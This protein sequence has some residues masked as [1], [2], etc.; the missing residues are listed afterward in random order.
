MSAKMKTLEEQ[1]QDYQR[2][3]AV[4]KE[5]LCAKEEHYNMLQADVEELRQRLEEKNR[6]IEKKTQV[7]MQATQE[8]NRINNELSE[9]KDHMDIK[10]RKINV[11][12]RKLE[13]HEANQK[14]ATG[15]AKAGEESSI[16]KKQVEEQKR[17]L[18]EQRR[19][20]E[21]HRKGLDTRVKQV[22]EKEKSIAEYEM[23]LK[24]RKENLD[25]REAQLQ[26]GGGQAGG[27]AE[28]VQKLEIELEVHRQELEKSQ[29]EIKR[30][31]EE[32]ERLLQLVQMS[33]EEH[34]QK[35]KTISDLQQALKNAQAKLRSQQTANAQREQA[36]KAEEDESNKEEKIN[37]WENGVDELEEL[38]SVVRLKEERI[39][40]LE[41]ALRESVRLT[42]DREKGLQQEEV[43]R[44]QIMEKVGKL[45]QRLLSLQTAHALRCSTCRPLLTRMQQLERRLTQLLDERGEHLQELTHMKQEALEAAISEKDAH[46]ALLEV[47]GLRTARHAEEAEQ[48]RADRKRLMDRLKL[49]T[50]HSMRLLQEYTPPPPLNTPGDNVSLSAS[51]LSSLQGY[52]QIDQDQLDNDERTG[53]DSSL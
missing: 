7:A 22:E 11:L 9:L 47:S 46:L 43:R 17:Q 5:S 8:R 1:H 15:A 18:E 42:A 40:E 37:N 10:D 52:S 14:L 30:S 12:Q 49:E 24:K 23:K 6:H 2:H 45:E 34:N 53:S 29:E 51:S 4:L 44:K 16:L 20:I 41:E 48:L 26:K 33:Q 36:R 3:I 38:L 25:Q 35:D 19:K 28:V 39:E 31:Q 27:G 32:M 50:E 21:E 13:L